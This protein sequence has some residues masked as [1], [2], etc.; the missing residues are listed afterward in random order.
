[1]E[2]MSNHI[3]KKLKNVS[4]F[5]LV[6]GI[7]GSIVLGFLFIRDERILIGL[8]VMVIGCLYQ[9]LACN[10]ICAFGEMA[11]QVT[12]QTKCIQKILERLQD[13]KETEKIPATIAVSD[14]S[15]YKEEKSMTASELLADKVEHDI[16]DENQTEEIIEQSSVYKL[17]VS[18]EVAPNLLFSKYDV[19]V[20]VDGSVQTTIAHGTEKII[21]VMVEQGEHTITFES[22][23]D[24]S[25]QNH[26]KVM[27]DKDIATHYRVVCYSDMLTVI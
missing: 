20:S 25:M 10:L 18:V 26:V 13:N 21:E 7:I 19:R 4:E 22:C 16:N 1:M 9:W 24:A 11:E 27:V 17:T 15:D 23:E 3:G 2:E 5:L 6:L 14:V 8:S 12:M